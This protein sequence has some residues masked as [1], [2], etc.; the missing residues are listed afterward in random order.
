MVMTHSICVMHDGGVIIRCSVS[1]D[2]FLFIK[3]PH[4][5]WINVIYIN[6]HVV[7]TVRTALLMVKTK[8]V[9]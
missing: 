4:F 3:I 5:P 2:G 7:I 8:R 1:R 9:A 6:S